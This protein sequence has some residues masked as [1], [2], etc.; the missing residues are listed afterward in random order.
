MRSS[1]KKL[2]WHALSVSNFCL[3]LPFADDEKVVRFHLSNEAE[4]QRVFELVSKHNLDVWSENR[5]LGRV[6]VRISALSLSAISA[7][8]TGIEH[9]IMI[10]DVQRLIDDSKAKNDMA[11]QV[12]ALK[13]TDGGFDSNNF[14]TAYHPY[15]QIIGFLNVMNTTYPKLASLET[16]GQTVEGN[17]IVGIHISS[18]PLTNGTKKPLIVYNSLQHAREWISGA[19]TTYIIDQ[20]LTGYGKDDG[21]TKML[22]AVDFFIVPVVNVDGYKWTWNPTGDRMWRKN[23]RQTTNKCW[24]I[25]INRNW[26][27]QFR[28]S[29]SS[30]ICDE[31]YAGTTGFSEPEN[32]AIGRYLK[33]TMRT[34]SYIDFHAFSQLLMWPWAYTSNPPPSNQ[35]LVAL[36][37]KMAK[38]I[39]SVHGTQFQYGQLY[40]TIYPAYGSSIDYALIVGV[41]LPFAVEL[42]DTG[43]YGFLLP[44]D[45][46]VPSGQEI[47]AAVQTMVTYIAQ[48]GITRS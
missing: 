37:T 30:E 11:L 12:A 1:C 28:A 32:A 41:P 18:G 46:I 40:Q 10:E 22:S 3:L 24:G 23:R 35:H 7:S 45:Q 27:F 42:R 48:N 25:D 29:P 33:R 14:F 31:T 43:T 6:D 17:P 4:A 20:L 26:D 44:P 38:V 8:L 15:E 9:E 39:A 21:V 16:I 34:V 13:S 19:V 47:F 36:G 5:A 2:P